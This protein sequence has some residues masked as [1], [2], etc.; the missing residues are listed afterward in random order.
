M[1]PKVD[2]AFK[3][4]MMNENARI[5]FLSAMLGIHPKD[6]RE[7][8]ILNT[9]LRKEHETDKLGIL[10]VRI[11][12]NSEMEI[13]VEIQL[14]ELAVW[15]ERSLFYLSKMFTEQIE[16][17]QNYTVLKKCVN[18]SIL[19]FKIFDD[20]EDFYSCF[21][22]R[23]DTRHIL[24]T[25]KIEFHVVELPKL[26]P[27]LKE[28]SSDRLLWAKFIN[29]DRKEELEMIA[30]QNSYIGSAFQQLEII[31][32]DKQKR[33]E[34]E[35][36]EKAIRDHNQVILEAELRGEK[37]VKEE[38]EKKLEEE[39]LKNIFTMISILLELNTEHQI[40]IEKL[41]AKYQL[42]AEKAK[43]YIHQVIENPVN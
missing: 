27:K 28:N 36:R 40:I 34:Y 43:E 3:E 4:I 11:L 17:G 5:G 8:H 18:I 21:H 30:N 35:A 25:D 19:D 9:F 13:D 10:D 42:P 2:F 29:A 6:I 33:M 7:T 38:A 41:E 24:Y 1:K 14:S 15:P 12:L 31:S 22:L 23:E 39:R 37:R 16:Q 26:P 32:Q 20:E